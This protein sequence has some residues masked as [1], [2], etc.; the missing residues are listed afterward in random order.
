MHRRRQRGRLPYWNQGIKNEWQGGGNIWL[1]T[2]E[3]QQPVITFWKN[4]TT[5]RNLNN[6]A[7]NLTIQK[8]KNKRSHPSL[9]LPPSLFSL[10]PEQKS[11][12]EVG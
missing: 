4:P 1:H 7:E 3:L 9:S 8:E 10:S 12:R 11:Q 6:K 5:N 2:V